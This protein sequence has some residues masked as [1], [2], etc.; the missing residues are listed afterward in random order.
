MKYGT[1]EERANAALNTGMTMDEAG[2]AMLRRDVRKA[3][4][5]INRL[6]AYVGNEYVKGEEVDVVRRLNSWIYDEV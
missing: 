3:I 5:I 1:T 2:E 4:A 6:N